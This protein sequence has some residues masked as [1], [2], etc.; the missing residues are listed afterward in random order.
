MTDLNRAII[1]ILDGVGIGELP[2]AAEFGDEGSNTLGNLAKAVG[3][4]HLPNFEKLGLGNISRLWG[5]NL[6]TNQWPIMGNWPNCLQVRIVPP[7]I[8]K[9]R[10]A[11]SI[12]PSRL[13]QM[14]SQKKYLLH[15][16]KR[17]GERF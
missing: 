2:D 16:G 15:F 1:V 13:I 4:L 12:L 10:D 3:G 5:S 8:G 7:G 14:V 11:F 9:L 6:R 17:L